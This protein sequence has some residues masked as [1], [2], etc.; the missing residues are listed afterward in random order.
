MQHGRARKKFSPMKAAKRNFFSIFSRLTG[1]GSARFSPSAD[2]IAF[3][4]LTYLTADDQ[5]TS[6]E[7]FKINNRR[8]RLAA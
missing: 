1:P 6:L 3:R 4:G 5:N 2:V 7:T 8:S